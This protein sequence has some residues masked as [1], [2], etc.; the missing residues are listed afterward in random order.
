MKSHFDEPR[1]S[2]KQ[3]AEMWAVDR[4]TVYTWIRE[5][6]LVAGYVGDALRIRQSD[7]VAFEKWSEKAK[8][9]TPESLSG[10]AETTSMSST[11]RTD[12]LDGFRQAQRMKKTLSV[13]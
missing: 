12:D 11:K 7:W 8:L 10:K 5:Q 6:K 2:V 1:K 9:S 13:S 4:Q 3:L